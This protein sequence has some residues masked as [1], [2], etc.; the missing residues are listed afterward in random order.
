M[1]DL[2]V[3]KS[4]SPLSQTELNFR[5]TLHSGATCKTDELFATVYLQE[6]NDETDVILGLIAG[7]MR[8]GSVGSAFSAS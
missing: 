6:G 1:I 7:S 3:L 2:R 4:D 5:S 8:L